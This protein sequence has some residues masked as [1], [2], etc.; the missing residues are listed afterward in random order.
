MSRFNIVP[1][2]VP[3]GIWIL[4][5]MITLWSPAIHL[6]KWLATPEGFVYTWING[7]DPAGWVWCIESPRYNFLSAHDLARDVNV[8]WRADLMAPIFIP[9][10]LLAMLLGIPSFA[11]L[12]LIEMFW[13]AL[14]AYI[15]FRF[16]KT[17]LSDDQIAATAFV[18]CYCTSG[19]SGWLLIGQWIRHAA[20]SGAW[21]ANILSAEWVG[22]N[23]SKSYEFLDGNALVPLTILN[24][25]NYA[26]AR[27]FGLLALIWVY[28]IQTEAHRV[29]VQTRK[30]LLAALGLFLCTFLHPASGLIFLL[31]W[32]IQVMVL[33]QSS[34]R[35][36]LSRK[37]WKNFWP[38][39]GFLAAAM[40]W[41]LYQFVPDAKDMVKEYVKQLYNADALLVLTATLPLLL[42]VL[43]PLL[44]NAREKLFFAVLI[45]AA[46]ITVAALSEWI[47]RDY[48]VWER[49]LMLILAITILIAVL[50]R[51]RDVLQK[52]FEVAYPHR[53]AVLMGCWL[54]AVT[55][56]AVSPHHDGYYAIKNDLV[57][58]GAITPAVEKLLGLGAFVYAARFKLG[59]WLPLAGLAA[60]MIHRFGIR[61]MSVRKWVAVAVILSLPSVILYIWNFSTYPYSGYIST[62]NAAA[63]EFIKSQTGKN[64]LCADETGKHLPNLTKKRTLTGGVCG[65]VNFSGRLEQI[66]RF[67]GD[68]TA[69]EREQIID[70]YKLD[71]IFLGEDE[72]RLGGNDS[73]FTAYPK[74]YEKNGATV[75]I[76]TPV[77]ASK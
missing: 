67:Y 48:A 47:I 16:F 30:S 46:A 65:V 17:F 63:F 12:V 9:H 26:I 4:I 58:F 37:Q 77:A 50:I 32:A 7:N 19:I 72:R 39:A 76:A 73:L 70:E 13:N 53:I 10:G 38:F 59:V 18:L 8:V 5:S 55:A 75:Y 61:Q 71:Y 54:V 11:M 33:R 51:K 1:K 34:L 35:D 14:A 15:T 43:V 2:G 74:L 25:P 40:I 31:M 52:C 49:L 29:K 24:R 6:V 57:S 22:E 41:Q 20:A 28:E 42:L 69:S 21:N 23:H 56:V 66:R 60:Y 3:N 62:S 45:V 44:R 27:V 68:A 64:V 36:I